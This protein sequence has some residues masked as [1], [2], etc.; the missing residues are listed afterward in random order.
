MRLAA[1]APVGHVHSAVMLH[2]GLGAGM[3]MMD[4]VK[5]TRSLGRK[6][7]DDTRDLRLA[8]RIGRRR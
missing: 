4:V 7:R 3:P 8:R 1:G 6:V 2:A 5:L